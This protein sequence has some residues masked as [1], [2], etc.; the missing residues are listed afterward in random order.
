MQCLL[1]SH[2]ALED[3]GSFEAMLQANKFAVEY[4]Q[5]GG[6]SLALQFQ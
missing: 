5:A 3:L 2:L 4:L 1:I 6:H